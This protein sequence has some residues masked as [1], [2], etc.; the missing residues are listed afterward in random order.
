MKLFLQ[1]FIYLVIFYSVHTYGQD[2]ISVYFDFSQ[3]KLSDSEINEIFSIPTKYDLSDLDSVH[4]IG[5][6]DS[7]DDLNTN[8]K[9]SE[10]RARNV[11]KY[12][13]R[14]IPKNIYK[15]PF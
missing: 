4:F 2:T 1:T 8:I 6:S 14:I 7:I 9:L 5:L 12:A 11:A 13:E 3:H 10:K 15:S